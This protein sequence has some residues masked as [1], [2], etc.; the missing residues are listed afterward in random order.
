MFAF[1]AHAGTVGCCCKAQPPDGCIARDMLQTQGAGMTGRGKLKRRHKSTM[2]ACVTQSDG[3]PALALMKA[4]GQL[5]AASHPCSTTHMLAR[6]PD[7]EALPHTFLP[8]PH[9]RHRSC[10][11]ACPSLVQQGSSGLGALQTAP[12]APWVCPLRLVGCQGAA[13]APG[14]ST[15]SKGAKFNQQHRTPAAAW[16]GLSTGHQHAHHHPHPFPRPFLPAT[17]H[18]A[19]RALTGVQ[20][21]AWAPAAPAAPG[22]AGNW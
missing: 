1:R 9:S 3:P 15:C 11:G 22:Q 18:T 4:L 16:T 20:L 12:A 13:G 8:G 5:R 17:Q 19:G 14:S 6:P 7:Q 2:H 21:L 10:W